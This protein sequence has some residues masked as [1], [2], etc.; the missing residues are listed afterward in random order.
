TEQLIP[1]DYLTSDVYDSLKERELRVGLIKNNLPFSF[2]NNNGQWQGMIISILDYIS[3]QTGL[4]FVE[5]AYDRFDEAEQGLLNNEVDIIGALASH[6][7]KGAYLTSLYYNADDVLVEVVAKNIK[8][9]GSHLYGA[10]SSNSHEINYSLLA[11]DIGNK[12]IYFDT[13]FDVLRKLES[14]L[15]NKAVVSLY[16]A[17]Y[18][19]KIS[20]RPYKIIKTINNQAIERVFSVR[21]DDTYLLKIIDAALSLSLPS[22]LSNIAYQWRYGPKPQVGIYAQYGYIIKPFSVIVI[23]CLI[24]YF[25]YSYRLARVLK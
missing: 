11:R 22:H 17:E 16:T 3:L 23:P 10:A 9:H 8:K 4:K 2:V 21:N 13:D 14:G 1:S 19:R 6:V 25:Y 20:S 5:V 18:Y 24:I 7:P 15:I 12:F